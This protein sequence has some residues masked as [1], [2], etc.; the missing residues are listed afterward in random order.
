[1]VDISFLVSERQQRVLTAVLLRP[2]D[3]F[4]LTAIMKIAGPGHGATQR[5]VDELVRVGL[6]RVVRASGQKRYLANPDHHIYTEL[7]AIFRIA[8]E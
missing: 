5:Y 7:C 1:M 6:V 4:S 3:E 2:G 8:L